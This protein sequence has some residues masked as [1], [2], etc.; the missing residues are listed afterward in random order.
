MGKVCEFAVKM[1]D[2]MYYCNKYKSYCYL[3]SPDRKQCIEIYGDTYTDEDAEADLYDDE[4][5]V[6]DSI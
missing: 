1:P 5:N 4:E 3:D 6:E 2:D